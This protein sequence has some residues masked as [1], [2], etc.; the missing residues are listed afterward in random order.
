MK[1]TQHTIKIPDN[2]I[3]TGHRGAAGLAPENTLSAIREGIKYA[4]RIEIDVHQ[5]K[6]GKIVVMHDASVNRTTNGKGKIKD[7]EWSYLSK[8]DA[9]S[10]FS[11][12]FQGEKIPLLEEVIDVVCPTKILLIEIKEGEYPDIEENIVNIIREKNVIDKVII[13]SFSTKILEKIHS[14]EPRITLHKLFA[15]QIYF[16]GFPITFI[17]AFHI[18]NFATLFYVEK[19]PY[20]QEYSIF[21]K[22]ITKH[23]IKNLDKKSGKKM[24]NVW[25]E[26]NPERA[27]KLIE[28]GVDGI[29]TD[30]PNRFK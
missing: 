9:G 12:K 23:F 22:F 14:I 8:L 21:H 5:S 2:I 25:V 16:F 7:L 29:I 24:I 30:Y 4:D 11:Q 3:I 27:H 15:K 18:Y 28:K 13:Q 10:W 17:Q 6:D 1:Y 26:N 20:I 19:Y